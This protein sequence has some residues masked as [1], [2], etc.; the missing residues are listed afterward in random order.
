MTAWPIGSGPLW[1]RF[2]RWLL[3]AFEPTLCG[4]FDI[5]IAAVRQRRPLAQSDVSNFGNGP[6]PEL[7][8]E[9]SMRRF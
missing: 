3:S 5:P 9:A 4:D 8:T 6:D 7:E 1:A 2:R